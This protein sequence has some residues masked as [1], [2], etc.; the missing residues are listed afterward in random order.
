[1]NHPIELDQCNILSSYSSAELWCFLHR[2]SISVLLSSYAK[3]CM[4][5][6]NKTKDS[7]S[8]KKLLCLDSRK[9]AYVKN[10]DSQYASIELCTFRCSKLLLARPLTG[11]SSIAH[12]ETSCNT[13]NTPFISSLLENVGL[14]GSTAKQRLSV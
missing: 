11:Q 7:N 10:G 5:R 6:A 8:M 2:F 12:Y 3:I 4:N 14:R 1:M 9:L 13:W